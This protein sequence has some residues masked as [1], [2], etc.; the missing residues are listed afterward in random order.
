M[1]DFDKADGITAQKNDYM[2][3]SS[4]VIISKPDINDDNSIFCYT[5]C[6]FQQQHWHKTNNKNN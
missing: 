6:C 1:N 3:L 2:K 5:K 4:C